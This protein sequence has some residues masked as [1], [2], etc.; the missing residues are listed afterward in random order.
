MDVLV[1]KLHYPYQVSVPYVD[2]LFGS[3]DVENEPGF[4]G[5]LDILY[6]YRAYNPEVRDQASSYHGRPAAVRWHDPDPEPLH[7][8]TQWFGFPLYYMKEGEAQETFNRSLD[9]FREEVNAPT[10]GS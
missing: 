2:A 8:R 10:P 9:W 6:T 1:E 3:M 4:R 7:G 5:E